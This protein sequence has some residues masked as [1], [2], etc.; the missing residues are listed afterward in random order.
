MIQRNDLVNLSHNYYG[1]AEHQLVCREMQRR[2]LQMA[3]E[4]VQAHRDRG[5]AAYALVNV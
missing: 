2:C 5:T 3:I 1:F 4:L